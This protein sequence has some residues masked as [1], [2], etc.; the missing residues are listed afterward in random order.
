MSA[1]LFRY[2]K[3]LKRLFPKGR[4]WQF[5]KDSEQDKLLEGLAA[6]PCRIDERGRDFLNE[7]DPNTTFEMLDNWERL[8]KIPDECT[9]DDADPTLQERRTRI[10]QKLT[11]GG[12]Q[13]DDFY[14]LIAAQLGYDV[15]VFDVQNFRDFR[16]GIST[17][18]EPLTNSTEPNGT[19]NST[20]WAFT[21]QIVGPADLVRYFRVGQSTVGDRLVLVENDTLECV[22]EKFKPAHTNVLF[23]FT[24]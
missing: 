21:F 19:T 18:G 5:V 3:L 9:P 12:G 23:S 15:G 14:I 24:L 20:G 7:M 8:L 17:V 2:K 22:I 16:V 6:E 11:T 4:A 10:L 1:E 13:N